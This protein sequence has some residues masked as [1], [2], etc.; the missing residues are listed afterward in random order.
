MKASIAEKLQQLAARSE[1]LGHLLGDPQV[2]SDQQRF[3]ELSKEYAQLEPVGNPV[4]MESPK[5]KVK[6]IKK[7]VGGFLRSMVDKNAG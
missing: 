4:Q 3:R 7:Q 6:R 1:E 5:Q 2:I